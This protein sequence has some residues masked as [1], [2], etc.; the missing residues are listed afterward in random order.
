MHGHDDYIGDGLDFDNDEGI[1]PLDGRANPAALRVAATS[2]M[3]AKSTRLE[4]D[5]ARRAWSFA[6]IAALGYLALTCAAILAF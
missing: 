4:V 5:A 3:D 2:E 1:H 6:V